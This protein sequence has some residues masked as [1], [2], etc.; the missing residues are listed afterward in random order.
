MTTPPAFVLDADVFIAAKNAYYA[1][2]I[3]PGFWGALLNAHQLGRA[4][5][6]D[7]V[8]NELLAGRKEEDLVP[9]VQNE[10]PAS[11]FHDSNA[12]EVSTAYGEIMLWVQ[13]NPRFL[14]RAKAK[15]A[16]AADGWLVAYAMVNETT[17]VTNEQ[18]RPESRNRVLLPDVC[19]QFGVPYR[20]VPYA[21][22]VGCPTGRVTLRRPR[23]PTLRQ[24]TEPAGAQRR[25]AP[26]LPPG[27]L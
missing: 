12:G 10:A 27:A 14:D 15:F 2:D 26:R 8:R 19:M 21:S 11:F 13:R 4:W 18:P 24:Q 25:S 9:W 6:I 16:T 22:G 23:A 20:H 7:R 5:S 1:F 17:I 3:C